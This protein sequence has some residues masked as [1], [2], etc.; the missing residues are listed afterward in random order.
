M[1]SGGLDPRLLGLDPKILQ[2][3]DENA[4]KSLGLDP[5]IVANLLDP[6]SSSSAAAG[7][8]STTSRNMAKMT[9]AATTT[10]SNL[11]VRPSTSTLAASNS[12]TDTKNSSSK[13]S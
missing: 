10:F 3:L 13:E 8:Q 12:K 4:L 11:D 9:T 1:D 5:Q 6:K 2:G 7:D